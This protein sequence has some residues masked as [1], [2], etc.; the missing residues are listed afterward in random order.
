MFET[1]TKKTVSLDDSQ[2][3]MLCIGFLKGII[4]GKEFYT[5]VDV[6]AVKEFIAE[7]QK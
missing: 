2:K 1:T 4:N 3:V 7:I 6:S 5:T